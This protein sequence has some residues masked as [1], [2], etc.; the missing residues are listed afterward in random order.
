MN[1]SF[2]VG[3]VEFILAIIALII[4]H[5]FGHFVVSRLLHVEVEEFGLG[6]PPRITKLFRAW[7][8]D[9]TLNALP[10]GGFVRPKGENDPTV[11][12]GLA[13]ASP[14]VRLAVLF[15]GPLMN[16]LVGVLLYAIIFSKIG[17]P[18][19][20]RVQVLD[21]APNSPAAAAGLKAGD[22]I[23]RINTQAINS[24]TALQQAVAASLDKTTTLSYE[25]SGKRYQVTLV[26]RSN[27]P[28]GQ[29]AIGIVMGNPTTPVSAI[30][31]LPSG[32]EAV[33]LH[34]RALLALP[35][36][37]IRGTASP[38]D[39]RFVGFKGMFDIYQ[40]A[41]T[42][43]PTPGTPAG[44]NILLFFTNVTIS[45]GLINLFPF[46]ALDGGRI[47]FTLPEII[48]RRR[49]PTQYENLINLVGFGLLI[50]LMLYINLQDF[51]SPAIL[52]K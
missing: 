30:Q 38:T 27:P 44:V 12:G 41:R 52:P 10:L 18:D 17:M 2:I 1:T 26:P 24:T 21:V 9:F 3:L 45:L 14:W 16:L 40:Q 15:A 49:I 47:L 22:F 37:M 51:I 33:F 11:E 20:T 42:S 32:F 31:S 25:R 28:Q 13:A 6:F 46:P 19:V 35:V 4:I 48:I 39:G 23:T 36:Q 43:E 29:G 34:S 50:L 5:E 7:G 8:T